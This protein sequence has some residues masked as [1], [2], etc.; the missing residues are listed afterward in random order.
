MTAARRAALVTAA[1]LPDLDPDD[2]PLV[3]AL[4]ERGVLAEAAVWDD[5]DADWSA[6]D[7][8]VVR[9]PWDYPPRRGEFVAWARRVETTTTLLN[10]ADVLAWNT[11]KT[12]LAELAEHGVPVVPTRFVG[13]DPPTELPHGELVIKPSVGAG[14]IDAARFGRGDRDA[15]L[16]HARRL[17]AA[18]RTVLIQPYI[19]SVDREGET[20]LVFIGG[21][22]SH[23]VRKGAMLQG[24]G[25]QRA[26]G[27]YHPETITAAQPTSEQRRLAEAVLDALPW[28]RHRLLY[29]RVDVVEG[30]GRSPLLLEL[31][32]TEP[33]LFLEY[34]TTG[35]VGRLAD[36]VAER[37][38]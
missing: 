17:V 16:E 25:P 28:P 5:P 14:S 38:S 31:E 19:A 27:L 2:R 18:G 37:I 29:A 30:G 7:V 9:S 20:A 35:A 1:Q 15:A 10:P 3:P 21:T 24:Q 36:A 32:L 12:Y 11:D 4:A 33:S 23:A 6:Y 22:Y 34:T 13:P 26:A 8:V